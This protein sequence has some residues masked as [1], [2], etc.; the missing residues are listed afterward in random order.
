MHID[1]GSPDISRNS[2]HRVARTP[3]FYLGPR[4]IHPITTNQYLLISYRIIKYEKYIP[5][6][7]LKWLSIFEVIARRF[8]ARKYI[9]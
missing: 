1:D 3:I 9:T 7:K 4:Q 8:I 2:Y 6:L 5:Y